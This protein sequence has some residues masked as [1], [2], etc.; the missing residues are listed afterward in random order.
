MRDESN[1]NPS[2]TQIDDFQVTTFE[3]DNDDLNQVVENTVIE[4]DFNSFEGAKFDLNFN[5][6]FS[7]N[8]IRQL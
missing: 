7:E 6:P 8:L 1:D 5:L 3:I 4:L 2:F